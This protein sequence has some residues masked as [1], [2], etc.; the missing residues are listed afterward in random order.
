MAQIETVTAHPIFEVQQTAPND[1]ATIKAEFGVYSDNVVITNTAGTKI[2]TLTNFSEDWIDF[3]N[4]GQFIYYGTT[5]P[6]S[7][8]IKVWYD[9][10]TV[11]AN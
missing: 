2:G 10:T 4:S 9:T 1:N 6:S 11:T 5:T 7:S 8:N 3:K